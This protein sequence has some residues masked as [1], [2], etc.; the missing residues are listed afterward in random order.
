MYLRLMIMKEMEHSD[1]A[2]YRNKL[3]D[4]EE[5]YDN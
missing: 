5:K 3:K 4:L 1:N 2:N